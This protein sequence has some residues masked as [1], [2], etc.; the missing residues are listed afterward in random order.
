MSKRAVQNGKLVI[1]DADAADDKIRVAAD[2]DTCCE[3]GLPCTANITGADCDFCTVNETPNGFSV[4]VRDFIGCTDCIRCWIRS[5]GN[6]DETAKLFDSFIE[7]AS[8]MPLD[9]SIGQVDPFGTQLE[10]CCWDAL[11]TR[12]P[13]DDF[14]EQYNDVGCTTPRGVQQEN[15]YTLRMSMTAANTATFMLYANDRLTCAN[16]DALTNVDYRL[17]YFLATG[18][19]VDPCALTD[20]LVIQNGLTSGDCGTF[21]TVD[22]P[23]AAFTDN[24]LYAGYGGEIEICSGVF[25]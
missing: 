13:A 14:V 21:T 20:S 18:V 24:V 3:D 15:Q 7:S 17:I 6:K 25:T 5:Q 23:C 4:K 19:T 1:G 10:K 11:I 9:F 22:F 8:R 16:N 12:N 2:C